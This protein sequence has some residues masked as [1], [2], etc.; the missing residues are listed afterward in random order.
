M[1]KKLRNLFFALLVLFIIICIGSYFYYKVENLSAIDAIYLA[2]MT[3]TTVG[4]GDYVP[5]TYGGKIFTI[6]YS[7]VG[8]GVAFYTLALIARYLVIKATE[9]QIKRFKKIVKK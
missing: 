9:E 6:A 2:T 5:K 8:I 4:Y 1:Q 3:I 7:L